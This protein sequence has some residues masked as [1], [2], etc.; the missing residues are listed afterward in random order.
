MNEKKW[1]KNKFCERWLNFYSYFLCVAVG[2]Q[3][4]KN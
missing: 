3:I 2:Y 4:K 1:K